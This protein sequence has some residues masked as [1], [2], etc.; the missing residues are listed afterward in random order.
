M[1]QP[2]RP[3]VAR[4]R[5]CRLD[6]R[7]QFAKEC[8]RTRPHGIQVLHTVPAVNAAQGHRLVDASG[9]EAKQKRHLHQQ[10]RV[11]ADL[12]ISEARRLH[13]RL[14]PQRQRIKR[15][16]PLSPDRVHCKE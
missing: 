12:E 11:L 3:P 1:R 2:K 8:R 15:K 6:P 7:L 4:R 13:K 5:R 16:P 14:A 9:I 10:Q